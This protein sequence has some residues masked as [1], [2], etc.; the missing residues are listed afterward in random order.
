LVL[1]VPLPSPGTNVV[2]D[3]GLGDSNAIVFSRPERED[4]P[5]IGV[6]FLPL[7]HMLSV[8]S[9]VSRIPPM[10]IRAPCVHHACTIN[11]K[12]HPMSHLFLFL[13]PLFSLVLRY[14][15]GH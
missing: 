14:V 3:W 1:S 5:M 11:N 4:L 13:C 7:F 9:I 8:P 12:M 15:C 10:M 6:S 2:L